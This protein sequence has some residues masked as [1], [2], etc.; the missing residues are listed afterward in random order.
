MCAVMGLGKEPGSGTQR[1]P[2]N[3]EMVRM[4]CGEATTHTPDG[5]SPTPTFTYLAC[6][7][8]RAYTDTHPYPSTAAVCIYSRCNHG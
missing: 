3:L 7:W 1:W 2:L 8:A 6:P 4:G 5:T